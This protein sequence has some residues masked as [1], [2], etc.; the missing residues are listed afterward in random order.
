M[1][2][3]ARWRDPAWLAGAET[4]IE[5]RL[6]EVGLIRVGRIEQPHVLPWSTVLRIPTERGPVW[7]KANQPG[8][9]HEAVLVDLL[10]ARRPDVVPPLL[11]RDLASGWM[12]MADAG[13][14]LR[15]ITDEAAWLAVWREVLPRYAALQL[16]SS[17]DLPTMARAGVPAVSLESL[18]GRYA[19]LLD[20]VGAERRFRDAVPEVERLCERLAGFG[21]ADAVQHDDLHD[22]QIFVDAGTNRVL[23]WGDAC[24]SHPFFTLSVTLEGVVSWGVADVEG[25]VDVRPFLDAYL[26]PFSEAYGCDLHPAV[27]PALRLG[28]VCRAVNGHVPGDEAPTLTRLRMFLDGRP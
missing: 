23:D 8:L 5:Q 3:A 10:A 1:D 15:A 25:S 12:L 9:R 4:W 6:E 16:E 20:L 11:A 18:P 26:A 19:E 17:A 13:T 14:P 28:W 2:E 24:L 27:E 21:V 22:A 7:F